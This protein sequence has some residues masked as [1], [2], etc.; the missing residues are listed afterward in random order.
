MKTAYSGEL[1]DL[2]NHIDSIKGNME[3]WYALRL[4]DDQVV[5]G[6]LTSYEDI[7]KLHES[8]NTKITN[9]TRLV[10]NALVSS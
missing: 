2:L 1:V 10:R 9:Q 8:T 3:A 4:E 7:V 5:G 6:H